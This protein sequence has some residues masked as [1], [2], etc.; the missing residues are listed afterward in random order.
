MSED[1]GR[2]PYYNII[3]GHS[4]D[5]LSGIADGIFSVGMTLLVL[6]L[7]VPA[8]TGIVSEGDLARKLAELLPNAV[9]YAMSFLTLGIFW[10]A[11]AATTLIPG[12]ILGLAMR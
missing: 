11:M 7:T 5:R 8:A 6:G 4:L 3:A 2:G 9:T 10:V 1:P 12:R